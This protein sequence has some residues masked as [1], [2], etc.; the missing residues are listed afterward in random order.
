M[1]SNRLVPSLLFCECSLQNRPAQARLVLTMY[2][3]T[4]YRFNTE[5]A[6]ALQE[7]TRT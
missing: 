2:G 5:G 1:F 6:N 4:M 7:Y 3:L